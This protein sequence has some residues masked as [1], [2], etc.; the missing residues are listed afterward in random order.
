MFTLDTN[1]ISYYF[2]GDQH[3][4]SRLQALGPA[5]VTVPAIVIY[6]LRYGLLRLNAKASAP[7]LSA[8]ETLVK[9]LQILAFDQQCADTAAAI[10]VALEKRG[11]P[12]GPHDLLIAATALRYGATLVTR[13][14][15]EFSRI[16]ALN[17]VNWHT[18]DAQQ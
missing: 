8:L 6:E 18:G 4:V 3:V 11:E 2:R 16:K 13:N 9:P 10:R 1:T 7:R 15:R 5:E 17:V 14:V 12:I